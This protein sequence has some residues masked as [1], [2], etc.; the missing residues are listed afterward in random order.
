MLA[1][2]TLAAALATPVADHDPFGVPYR[3][4]DIWVFRS[5][6]DQ[7]PRMI[8]VALHKDVWA[9]YD[10]TLCNLYQVWTGG[11]K[12]DGSV[13]TTVHGPQPTSEGA[14]YI[15]NDVDQETWGLQKGDDVVKLTPVY[16]GYKFVDGQVH[17][18][19]DLTSNKGTVHVTEVPEFY[20]PGAGKVGLERKLTVSGIPAGHS[21]TL[22]TIH[23]AETEVAVVGGVR[24]TSAKGTV[25]RLPVGEGRTTFRY[26][27]TKSGAS[28]PNPKP[29]P[30]P[31]QDVSNQREP[32]LGLRVYFV[33]EDM[34]RIPTLVAGQTGNVNKII[35]NVNLTTKADFGGLETRFLSHVSGYINIA[36]A[37]KYTFRLDSN[38]GSRLALDGKI[39]FEHDGF[40]EMGK[41]G[42]GDIELGTGEHSIFIEHFQQFGGFGLR[43]LWKK[44]GDK[45][46]EIV[47]PS[48]FTT[49][50]GE[51]RVVA[52]G[53]KR[54]MMAGARRQPGDMRP[55]DKVHPSFD[56]TQA[57]PETFKPKVGG[58]DF[59]PDGDMVVCCWEPDGGVYRVHNPAAKD[60]TKIT[61]KRIGAGLAEP[62]GIKVV[63]GQIYVLQ[64][65]E[66]TKLVDNDGDGITDEYRCVA[67]GWQVSTNFHEFSF[68]LPYD[69]KEKVFYAS[70]AIAI[71]PGG[72]S[73]MKQ[74]PN[75]G[76]VLKIRM[77]GSY[78]YIAN[79]LR[80]PNGLWLTPE[81]ELFIADN[82][83]DWVPAN[84][85]VK[86][87][88]GAWYGNRSVDPQGTEGKPAHPP[89]VWLPENEI[90]NSPSNIVPL[91]FGPYKGQW[92]FGDV[93]YGGLQRLFMESVGGQTQ[94][95]IV[96]FTAG[97]E[98]GINRTIVG[99]DGSLYVGGVGSS[100]NWGQED[101][102]WYGLQ[103]LAYNGKPAYEILRATAMTNGF[104][105]EFTE[106]VAKGI[107]DT[108]GF[109]PTRQWTYIA[110][111]EYG[112]P[113]IDETA[114]VPRSVT[115]SNDRKKAFLEYD[116]LKEGYVV[117]IRVHPSVVSA[118]GQS[119]WSTEVYYT[120]NKIPA[121]KVG[122]VVY[123]RA[124]KANV[125]ARD[126]A[127]EGFK[128]LFDG[129]SLEQF[130]GYRRADVPGAWYIEDGGVAV[131]SSNGNGGDLV[132]K[133]KFGD[134]E[135]RF[136]WKV[137]SGSNSGVM[138]KV[139][140]DEDYSF[141]SG[142]EYQ[143]LDNE[144]HL[145]GRN[146][147]TSA[148]ACYGLYAPPMDFTR[149][150]GEWN[151]GRI[152]V[153]GGKVEH[154]LNGKLTVSYDLGSTEFKDKIAAAKFK[155]WPGFAKATEGHICLQDHGDKA[156]FRN[157]RVKKL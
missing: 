148:G 88:P 65:Q 151:D 19:F 108:P 128:M 12:F 83:G 90:A 41:P 111:S 59:L 26:A 61:V 142:P 68:G 40:M 101:K 16:R 156:A 139:T 122:K 8:T 84:K 52:P 79:G 60:P 154:W 125:L 24:T 115:W 28:A 6:L 96:R 39:V 70:L 23:R 27:W 133:E 20:S 29:K 66:L 109:F 143:V 93:T 117:D 50:K 38:D 86:I 36:K 44:P 10:T 49:G 77:D 155:N 102:L 54:V 21:L 131:D 43:L 63:D 46:F 107:G 112:G 104:E 33:D 74:L 15:R 97:L 81:G 37:G 127:K 157:I 124:E 147:L 72:K 5:V 2:L 7:H 78:D 119:L 144:K 64:K 92:A 71:D 25:L 1:V 132:T 113:N 42:D 85:I 145:D 141:K 14:P 47:P 123:E 45:D 89:V 140:E 82:Q 116:G 3:P 114:F 48:A 110:T 11:V 103:R 80:T 22:V 149:P 126:E 121:G 67:N 87:E 152:V 73:S 9:A 134:F 17:I 100:G 135:L 31:V 4:R 51:V 55:L 118:T 138:Y 35:P 95:G 30:T 62:L 130:R 99:P 56:L 94:G 150:V 146:P 18:S 129:K 137:A 98:A 76:S 153:K 53:K 136:Q 120:L 58:I 105:V 13:Y 106:P 57:R 69:A 91:D 32:G 34:S 75:R